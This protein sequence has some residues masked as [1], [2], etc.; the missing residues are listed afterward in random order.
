MASLHVYVSEDAENAV[1]ARRDNAGDDDDDYDDE[2][3][4]GER[5]R[6]GYQDQVLEEG[7]TV[8]KK[9]QRRSLSQR[10]RWT[11]QSTRRS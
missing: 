3:K 8:D 7:T 10:S 4:L 1:Q 5:R 2:L 9:S 6:Q 11:T